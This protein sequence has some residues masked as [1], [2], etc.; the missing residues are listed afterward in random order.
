MM[1]FLPLSKENRFLTAYAFWTKTPDEKYPSFEHSL[2]T[3]DW[4][5]IFDASE[6]LGLAP[7]IYITLAEKRELDF[8]PADIRKDFYDSFLKNMGRNVDLESKLGEIL[9]L[10]HQ[11]AI[12]LI[13]LKGA[14]FLDWIYPNPELRQMGDLDLLIKKED[15]ERGFAL[16]QSLGYRMHGS[17]DKP[18]VKRW[19][20]ESCHHMIPLHSSDRKMVVE[21]HWHLLR[22]DV[23]AFYP[24]YRGLMIEDF[25]QNGLTERE[26]A[27]FRSMVLKPEYN[28][29]HLSLHNMA[30]Q[31]YFGEFHMNNL[32]DMSYLLR[33]YENR[34]DWE[35]LHRI[36]CKHHL[37]KAVYF[38]FIMIQELARYPVD[39]SFLKN[40]YPGYAADRMFR[41]FLKKL[42]IQDFQA[43]KKKVHRMN[44]MML[45]DSSF[46]L[47]GTAGRFFFPPR[48]IMAERF[49]GLRN[50]P[51]LALTYL[52]FPL[53][54]VGR[55]FRR[56]LVFRSK[57][58]S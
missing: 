14:A 1:S 8:L 23:L 15:R 52:V 10:F 42:C 28:L 30:H 27:G 54:F 35:M 40:C 29:L 34:I 37:Q 31:I 13:V 57:K 5:Y 58:R 50:S 38:S 32:R 36:A 16:L 47:L 45:A 44:Q 20:D 43:D 9:E 11:K 48:K 39:E 6:F 25:W 53:T 2:D 18:E 4:P 46:S 17:H 24:F 26:V 41:S 56:L 21:L 3:L 33:F 19:F 49:P 51:L 22:S 55:L 12:P 7:A